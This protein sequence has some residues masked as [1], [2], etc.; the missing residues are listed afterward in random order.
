ME[1]GHW[2]QTGVIYEIY[3]RSFKDCDGDGIG[4]LTGI[5]HRLDH[6]VELGVNTVWLSPIFISPMRDF[7][8]DI[9]D[10]T[11]GDQIFGAL[12]DFD[13]LLAAAHSRELKILFG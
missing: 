7:G 10:Y 6:L 9:A 8:Y 3:P 4:D 1:S 12:A 5:T 11:A 2:W 13:A